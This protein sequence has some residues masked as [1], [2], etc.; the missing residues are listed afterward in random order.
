M[1]RRKTGQRL[2]ARGPIGGAEGV[3]ARAGV[4]TRTASAT[5]DT[6]GY[7]IYSGRIYRRA[8]GAG[9]TAIHPCNVGTRALRAANPRGWQL[10]T[11]HGYD[12]VFAFIALINVA[13]LMI[14]ISAAVRLTY[15]GPVFFRQRR[16]GRDGRVFDVLKFRTMHEGTGP[17]QLEPHEGC[18]P[19]GEDRRTAS[20]RCSGSHR[21]TNYRKL[22]NVVLGE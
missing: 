8:F 1:I 9:A 17:S 20:G 2:T 7:D 5:R 19:G 21:G 11:K 14:L 22:I 4:A 3:N 16:V 10:V 6:H 18:A 15:L 13:P 12:R